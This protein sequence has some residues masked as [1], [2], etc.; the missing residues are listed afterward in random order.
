[1]QN[2]NSVANTY[3]KIAVKDI[4]NKFTKLNSFVCVF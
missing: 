1:M 3:T 2:Q 4:I